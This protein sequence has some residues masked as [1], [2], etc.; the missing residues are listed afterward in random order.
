MT[1]A[2]EVRPDVA[3]CGNCWGE[4]EIPEE[5]RKTTG[6][7]EGW[8]TALIT[9]NKGIVTN[10]LICDLCLTA[11]KNALAD[12]RVKDEEAVLDAQVA[13]SVAE[14][15][16][17]YLEHES[18]IDAVKAEEATISEEIIEGRA[19]ELSTEPTAQEAGTVPTKPQQLSNRAKQRAQAAIR[20]TEATEAEADKNAA[21]S[22]VNA[23]DAD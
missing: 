11:I 1:E 10:S 18:E 6:R 16:A 8:A 14:T 17:A 5:H 13:A 7:P 12:R 3:S 22:R 4:A 20:K 23:T 21:E 19:P 15:D 9:T 2:I